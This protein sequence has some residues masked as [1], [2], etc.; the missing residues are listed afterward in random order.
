MDTVGVG[1]LRPGEVAHLNVWSSAQQGDLRKTE[2]SLPDGTVAVEY[3]EKVRGLTA[4]FVRNLRG[5]MLGTLLL[6]GV[7]LLYFG[8]R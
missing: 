6:L 2:V 5:L 1:S 3:P 4:K 8:L 7:L